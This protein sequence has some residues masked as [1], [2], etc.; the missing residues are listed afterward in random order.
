MLKGKTVCSTLMGLFMLFSL[1]ADL[2][3]QMLATPDNYIVI[4]SPVGLIVVKDHGD[5]GEQTGISLFG[6]LT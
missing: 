5:S 6:E 2:N 4:T 3:I 1:S